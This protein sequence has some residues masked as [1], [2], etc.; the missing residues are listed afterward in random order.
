V[1]AG[2]RGMSFILAVILVCSGI[3]D[4]LGELEMDAMRQEEDL[5]RN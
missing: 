2:W 4:V 3:L 1:L 5:L